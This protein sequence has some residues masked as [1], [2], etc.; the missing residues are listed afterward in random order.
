MVFAKIGPVWQILTNF[1]F[2]RKSVQ[3]L[4]HF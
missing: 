3:T 2:G 4:L 1:G